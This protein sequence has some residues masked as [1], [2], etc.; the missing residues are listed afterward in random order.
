MANPDFFSVATR[1]VAA[2]GWQFMILPSGTGILAFPQSQDIHLRF[3]LT[4][5]AAEAIAVEIVDR[6]GMPVNA[7]TRP[8]WLMPLDLDPEIAARQIREN[9]LQPFHRSSCACPAA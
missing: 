7:T 8:I 9:L 4:G 2:L 6:F 5:G 3:A 1:T